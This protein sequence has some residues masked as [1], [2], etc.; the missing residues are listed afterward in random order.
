MPKHDIIAKFKGQV[1]FS[2]TVSK[3]SAD[4]LLNI[5]DELERL[6]DAGVIVRLLV[7]EG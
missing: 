2:R 6:D 1:D 4:R 5:I 3:G 7:S